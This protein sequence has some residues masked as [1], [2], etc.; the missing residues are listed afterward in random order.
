ME[1]IDQ[2]TSESRAFVYQHKDLN[3]NKP[4]FNGLF[5]RAP[6]LQ[7]HFKR[8][9]QFDKGVFIHRQISVFVDNTTCPVQQLTY[10]RSCIRFI[11][12]LF[13]A[14]S[15]RQR[16]SCMAFQEI[17]TSSLRQSFKGLAFKVNGVKQLLSKKF[18]Q[19]K[20]MKSMLKTMWVF[21]GNNIY[22]NLLF[23]NQLIY[24]A[25]KY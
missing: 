13:E 1:I 10:L 24:K 14:R 4:T 23:I 20:T 25:G 15:I 18:M 2:S 5:I 17:T 6:M 19:G 11:D 21:P 12:F 22:V 7:L 16:C 9:N 8:E 3:Q